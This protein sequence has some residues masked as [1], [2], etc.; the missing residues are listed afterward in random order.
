MIK[1]RYLKLFTKS[2]DVHRRPGRYVVV[3]RKQKSYKSIEVGYNIPPGI[4]LKY[5][6]ISLCSIDWYSI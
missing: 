3:R 1:L 4:L 6:V 5:L 2:E